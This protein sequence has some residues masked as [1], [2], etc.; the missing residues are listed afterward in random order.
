MFVL[1]PLGRVLT[2][3]PGTLTNLP[4]KG[5]FLITTA[6]IVLMIPSIWFRSH[7]VAKLAY[8]LAV[9]ALYW[10]AMIPE[11]HELLRLRREG[12]MEAFRRAEELWVL[13]ADGPETT[14]STPQLPCWASSKR[15]SRRSRTTPPETD[16]LGTSPA[17]RGNG[18]GVP[19]SM[20]ARIALIAISYGR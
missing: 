10:S 5:M 20:T 3:V 14:D 18:L 2:N 1:D 8:V 19:C 12:Q 9:N 15:R 6:G 16:L 11:W 17:N 7:Y 4:F 13:R